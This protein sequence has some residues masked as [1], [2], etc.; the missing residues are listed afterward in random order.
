MNDARHTQDIHAA[1]L[2]AI[3]ICES[4]LIAL[5][6]KGL[7]GQDEAQFV[8]EDAMHSHRTSAHE[9]RAKDLHGAAARFI[10]LI[11]ANSNA[12]LGTSKIGQRSDDGRDCF[13]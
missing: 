12:E 3:T 2:A 13:K 9:G 4:L 8:L 1:G 7:L 11:L 6:E 10:E 5:T